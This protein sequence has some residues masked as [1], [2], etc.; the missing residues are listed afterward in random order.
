MPWY[1]RSSDF[2]FSVITRITSRFALAMTAPTT[3]ASSSTLMIIAPFPTPEST[4]T[5]DTGTPS[6][7]PSSVAT[8]IASLS[9]TNETN[10]TSSPSLTFAYLRPALVDVS[11]CAESEKRKPRPF[12]VS[13]MA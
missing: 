1:V 4:L 9:A 7:W 2:S 11:R 10:N 5:S 3:R 8:R 6:A 12:F 13:A